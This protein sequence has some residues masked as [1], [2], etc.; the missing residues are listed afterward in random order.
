MKTP[1]DP[2]EVLTTTFHHPLRLA[3]L[4]SLR[5]VEAADFATLCETFDSTAPEMSR[6]LGLLEREGL[7]QMAKIKRDTR[8]ISVVRLSP[9]GRAEF[10][11]YLTHLRRITEGAPLTQDGTL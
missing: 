2:R 4:A 7:I 9:D 1:G 11:R 5:Q 6:Q 3:I 8:P 10:E